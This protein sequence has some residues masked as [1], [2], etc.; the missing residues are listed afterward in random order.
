MAIYRNILLAVDLTAD[1]VQIA[2]RAKTVAT[3]CGA[4]LDVVHVGN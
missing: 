4:E 2:E 3:A 1:S